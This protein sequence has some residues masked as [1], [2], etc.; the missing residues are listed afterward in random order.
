VQHTHTISATCETQDKYV[1]KYV[2]LS[3]F[4]NTHDKRT[5]LQKSKHENTKK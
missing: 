1:T 5:R 2:K 4:K 3:L